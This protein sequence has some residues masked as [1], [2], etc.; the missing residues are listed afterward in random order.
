VRRFA[1]LLALFTA[2]VV[3]TPPVPS[4]APAEPP[5]PVSRVVL[6]SL[7]GLSAD[8]LDARD[9]PAF[10]RLERE[11]LVAK[12][13]IP[14][15]P[16]QTSVAHVA[17]LTGK[18]PRQTGIV[19][20]RMRAGDGFTVDIEAETLVE[21]A[22]R[23]GKRV[24]AIAFPT[25]DGRDERRRADFG[26]VWT[27]A[28]TP[29]RLI[30][31]KPE[32]F[33][34][35]WVPPGW[36]PGTVSRA[37]VEWIVPGHPPLKIDVVRAPGGIAIRRGEEEIP[38]DADGWFSIA[39][40]I[41]GVL[42]GSWSRLIDD[43]TLFWGSISRVTAYPESFRRMIEHEAGFPPGPGDPHVDAETFAQQMERQERFYTTAITTAIRRMEFDLLLAYMPIID[44]TEHVYRT[45]EPPRARAY[46]AA[47]RALG[48][49]CALLDPA[50]DAIVVTGDHGLSAADTDVLVNQLV[51]EWGFG[52]WEVFASGNVANLYGDD[53]PDELVARLQASGFFEL[54]TRRT[55]HMHANNGD[56][57]AYAYPNVGVMTG[58]GATVSRRTSGQH[59]GLPAH[60]QFHTRL[61]AWGAA[62]QPGV[63]PEMAQTEVAPLV[64]GL[65]QLPF[66]GPAA[67]RHDDFD[68]YRPG[69][70]R[71]AA[72]GR[73]ANPE[74][75]RGLQHSRTDGGRVSSHR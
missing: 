43:A 22:R 16:T 3:A 71:G 48:A 47:D 68:R 19:A 73:H 32:D 59:G 70:R 39:E 38:R 35:D 17:I 49:I 51:A 6:L 2:C 26:L 18:E 4:P 53:R 23:S 40:T 7:D 57:V 41:D 74:S 8:E 1:P 58:E 60:R 30:Q 75:R 50:R 33:Q 9:L 24:G 15:T 37:R 61:Y 27:R 20:N 42:Y 28:V 72:A 69:V 29:A 65:L 34:T 45:V 62:I 64:A 11:G 46:A 12:R 31:L 25:V 67:R 56:I 54:V 5:P 63:I 14:V 55:P 44:Q 66:H 13:V 10:K 36:T 21:A 52:S